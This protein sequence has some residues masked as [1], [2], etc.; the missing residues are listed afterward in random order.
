M[1]FKTLTTPAATGID[2]LNKQQEII[3]NERRK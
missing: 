3:M 1:E 2:K